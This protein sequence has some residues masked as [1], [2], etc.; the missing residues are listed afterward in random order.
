MSPGP[1][2]YHLGKKAPEGAEHIREGGVN[3]L[4]VSSQTACWSE[5]CAGRTP[6]RRHVVRARSEVDRIARRYS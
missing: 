3:V 5:R 6:T 4:L 2:T 1:A